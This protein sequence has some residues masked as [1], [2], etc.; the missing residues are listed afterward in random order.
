[1]LKKT[2]KY[3]DLEGND[4]EDDFY[5]NLN[6][7]E[8][9]EL[10]VKRKGGL[11]AYMQ[12]LIDAED[13][14]QIIS[15]FKEVIEMSIGKRSADGKKFIKNQE[16]RDEFF[17]SDAYSSLLMEFLTEPSEQMGAAFM[18]GI[19]P[20]DIASELPPL[21]KSGQAVT[22]VHLPADELPDWIKEGRVPTAAEFAA[23]TDEQKAEA[24]RR[25]TAQ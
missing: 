12:E 22:D 17:Q 8:I 25:K 2:I 21:V 20:A 19:V 7:A 15:V 6:K 13:G 9:L 23:A 1:M 5:F 11:E 14:G 16:L 4:V 24:F 3:K 18:R 10:E